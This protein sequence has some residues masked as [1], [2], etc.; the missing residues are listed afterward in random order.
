MTGKKLD[1]L[2]HAAR[3]VAAPATSATLAEE[4]VRTLWQEPPEAG[5]DPLT[6]LEEL[7]V[8]FPR[9]AWLT[10]VILTLG[11]AANVALGTTDTTG[12]DAGLPPISAPWWLVPGEF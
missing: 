9:L 1:Q 2:F 5:C 3:G 8:R 6:L 7:N 11:V 12:L 10:L 4:V